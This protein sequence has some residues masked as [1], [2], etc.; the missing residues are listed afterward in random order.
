MYYNA[1]F[2]IFTYNHKMFLRV[3]SYMIICIFIKVSKN[4]N[5]DY[6]ICFAYVL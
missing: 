1:N 6:T 3:L 2:L 4:V 5:Y